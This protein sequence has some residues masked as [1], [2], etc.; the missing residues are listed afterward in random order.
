MKTDLTVF[1][2]F[3]LAAVSWLITMWSVISLAKWVFG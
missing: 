3:T 2:L 1:T